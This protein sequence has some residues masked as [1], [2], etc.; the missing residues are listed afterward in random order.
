MPESPDPKSWPQIEEIFF[1]AVELPPAQ[2][3]AY[4]AQTCGEDAELRREV[5]HLL[6]A[7]SDAADFLDLPAV[8]VFDLPE[9]P[10]VDV[11][12]TASLPGPSEASRQERPQARRK[13]PSH[14][15]PGDLLAGRFRIV[16]FIAA[17]G[18]GEVYEAE[19]GE[20][21]Q[22]VAIKTVRPEVAAN[23]VAMERF[24]REVRLA[25]QVTHPSV[26]RSFD[27][28]HH[29]G[30][31]GPET[32]FLSMELLA[33]ETLSERIRRRGRLTPAAALPI[34]EQITAALAA[35]HEQGIIHR[36]L[37][38]S[39]VVLVPSR[40]GGRA[41]V[42]DFGIARLGRGADDQAAV[43]VTGAIM[44]TPTHM[45]PE[46]LTGDEITP[47]TDVYALGVVMYEM[48]TGRY[49]FEEDEPWATAFKRLSE[50]PPS[51]RRLVPE[52]DPRWEEAI[53]RC[54]R[55][56]PA[57]R[58]ASGPEVIRF[59]TAP[60]R[61]RSPRRRLTAA[62]AAAALALTL[63]AGGA[64]L[65]RLRRPPVPA[66]QSSGEPAIASRRSLA[67]LGFK[68]LI[69]RN[70]TSWLSMALAEMLTVELGAGGILRT[71]SGETVGRMKLELE[72]PDVPSLAPDTLARVR[73]H[74]DADLVVL[75]SYFARNGLIRLDLRLEDAAAGETLALVT[76]EERET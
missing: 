7:D 38:G 33:G 42:T 9:E 67:V 75:G 46:Q 61:A 49:P 71:I 55:R 27:L 62:A 8:A 52:L 15:A 68:D 12:L 43:T 2:R 36:D 28:F 39:N 26:C 53:L 66:A 32:T 64:G 10:S 76:E 4:L 59:L 22:R 58:F 50:D 72:L 1:A 74:L 14:F 45:A 70:D 25:R 23:Q 57:E 48:I 19:D 18:M 44:G 17:G 37:K 41:V 63:V 54:L 21:G 69:G 24:R 34:V 31:S 6:A 16:R 30:E 5:E 40:Q 3:S 56:L 13:A 60:H 35:A 20:L 65:Y 73:D 47:A 11:A 29:Q 51:P